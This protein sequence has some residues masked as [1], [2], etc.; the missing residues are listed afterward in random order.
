MTRISI[1][2]LGLL[3]SVSVIAQSNRL[4]PLPLNDAQLPIRCIGPSVMSGRVVDLDVNPQNPEHFYVAFATGGLWVTH[5]NGQSFD[6]LFQNEAI[7]TIGDIAVDWTNETIWIGSGENNSSRSSYAGTGIYKSSDLGKTWM[8]MGL[9][10]SHHIGRIV[11]NPNNSNEIW[12][13]ALGHLYT[14]NK[15]RGIFHTTDGGKNWSHS[16]FI[17]T[18]TGA[19]D[20]VID[21]LQ[22]TTLYASFWEKDR[23]AWDFTES[24]AK[25]GI[26]T[27]KDNGKTWQN[28]IANQSV[29]PNNSGTG[30]IG[31]SLFHTP[32]KNILYALVD[33]QNHQPQKEGDAKKSLKKEDFMT[34]NE[35][36]FLQLD[37]NLL[38]DFLSQ[39][40]FPKKYARAVLT[41]KI[42]KHEIT[43]LALYDYVYDANKNLFDTPVYGAELYTY[44]PENRTWNKTHTDA[45]DDVFYTYGYYFGMIRV[46]PN[47]HSVVY[48][49]GVP[50]L[51]SEDGGA[52]FVNANPDNV[53]VDHHALW[54]NP[55]N[56]KHIINGSD[57]G[58][59]ISYDGG[60]HFT[61]CNHIPV[62]QAYAVAVDNADPYNV[63]TGLQDNGVWF[64]PHNCDDTN[65]GWRITGHNSFKEIMGGDGMQIQIDPRDHNIVYTGYQF[66]HYTKFN[67]KTGAET[68]I[69]P[70]HELGEKPL[71][72]NW[73]SPILLSNYN[74]D[75]FYICSNKVHRSTDG[76]Q[77]FETISGDLTHG[78]RS[79]DVPFGTLTCIHESPF[80]FGKL[81]VGSDDGLIHLSADNGYTWT[82]ITSNLPKDAWVSEVYF[83]RH[84]KNTLYVVLN[85]YR[86][87]DFAPLLFTS[88]DN[89][90]TWSSISNQ[91]PQQP[92]NAFKEDHRNAQVLYVGSDNGLYFSIDKGKNWQQF[93]ASL[94]VAAVHDLAIQEKENDLIIGTHG[95]SVWIGEIDHLP[96][97][98][99]PASELKMVQIDT[100]TFNSSWGE[101]WSKWLAPK[102][103]THTLILQ[104]PQAGELEMEVHY[105]DLILI[106]SKQAVAKSIV[107][108]DMPL[109]ISKEKAQ[110]LAALQEKDWKEKDNNKYYLQPGEYLIKLKLGNQSIETKLN[111]IEK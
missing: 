102:D 49:A 22:P 60:E 77:N 76:G 54:I 73:K 11:I 84:E 7:I 18:N 42:K 63:Y 104:T 21:P 10:D 86:N 88:I 87:D 3:S 65:P 33:N 89:G 78:F 52:T 44:S 35:A 20:L 107:Y 50:L 74:A 23:K 97:L 24:G 69:H 68:Y 9:T 37:T 55:K 51:K 85:K 8:N 58:V 90:K 61:N 66:G 48:I 71:R 34:M 4:N 72:W 64:A 12:V 1:F 47:D 81:V 45:L 67:L 98:A 99:A 95:R 16:L 105:K 36:Q 46:A 62:A 13:A 91:L 28:I 27:T 38:D 92:L 39:N 53:H 109:A 80:Q 70:S 75:I 100:L 26:Y 108:A 79:G 82:N 41:E 110:Q 17:D 93:N 94:P 32:E 2:L 56:P 106:S 43:P 6:P 5:N 96:L 83:S 19:I 25:S 59:Q 57:G 30:R 14:P 15:E 111:V 40:D 29:F 101:S 103:P 31:L